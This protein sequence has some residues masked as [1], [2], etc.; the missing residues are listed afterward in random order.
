MLNKIIIQKNS[1][2]IEAITKWRSITIKCL[3]ELV[4]YSESSSA[5]GHRIMRLEQ[6]RILRSNLQNE[7]NK[8]VYLSIELLKKLGIENLKWW[9]KKSCVN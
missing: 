5:F 1:E 6:G 9:C 2:I 7:F 3:E 8:I 4:G